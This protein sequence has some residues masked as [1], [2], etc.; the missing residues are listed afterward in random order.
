MVACLNRSFLNKTIE[1]CFL[2]KVLL[3]LYMCGGKR[4]SRAVAARAG[5]K[6]EQK[7]A[8]I[9]RPG[10]VTEP[11]WSVSDPGEGPAN[12]CRKSSTL[13]MVRRA[14][15]GHLWRR[16]PPRAPAQA[17][18][19]AG[20]VPEPDLAPSCVGI[21][22]DHRARAG[23]TGSVVL[24]AGFC[25]HPDAAHQGRTVCQVCVMPQHRGTS[26]TRAH[27][28]QFPPVCAVS[29]GAGSRSPCDGLCPPT[30]PAVRW[31]LY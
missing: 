27:L 2:E 5:R 24:A 11:G 29:S 12:L 18:E 13:C 19:V 30:I 23:A 31:V 17:G 22:P 10:L 3:W 4:C 8:S 7:T 6:D 9:P 28:V 25:V 20:R 21:S 15:Q 26:V 16:K 1:Y 14:G